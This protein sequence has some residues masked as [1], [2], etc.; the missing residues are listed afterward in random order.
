MLRSARS[1][2]ALFVVLLLIPAAAL[3]AR[4][5]EA[6]VAEIAAAV[7]PGT[8]V[9]G[10]ED[11]NR[12]R[13]VDGM[14]L[15]ADGSWA[16]FSYGT[17]READPELH[18]KSL[19]TDR[20]HVV[21]RATRPQLSDDGR[22]AAYRVHLGWKELEEA[23]GS[24]P[25]Q[26]QLMDLESAETW[27]WE[28]VDGFS[29]SRGGRA[30]AVKRKKS[31]E[32]AE[33]DGTDLIVRYL[34]NGTEELL[35]SVQHFAFNKTGT[36]LAY[37]VDAADN[38]GNG[39]HVIDLYSGV[40]RPLDNA[41]DDYSQ[42]AW[43]EDGNA[44]AVLRGS[45]PE[46][47]DERA[48]VLVALPDMSH[49]DGPQKVMFDASSRAEFPA[50]FVVSE[51]GRL[52]W[53]DDATKLFF[54]IKE[55]TP[56]PEKTEEPIADVN[57][58]H[59]ND[60][61]IQSVQKVQAERDKNFTYLS[62]LNLDTDVFVRL[63]T[64]R[65]RRFEMA[66]DGQYA[67]GYDYTDY[68]SD[69]E[70]RYADIYQ[71]NTATGEVAR[72]AEKQ[73]RTYGLSPDGSQ[74][75]VWRDDG[76]VGAI[77]GSVGLYD[78]EGAVGGVLLTDDAPVS[79][80]NE[81]WDYF[82]EKPAY[83]VAGWT[84]EGELL[85]NH[86]YDIWKHGT[87]GW[88]NLTGGYGAANEVRLRLVQTDPDADAFDLSEP[89]LLTAYGQWTKKSGYFRLP[90]GGGAPS[91]VLW[92]DKMV[93]RPMKARDADRYVFTLQ[94]F[95][96]F[97]DYWMTTIH[98]ESDWDRAVGHVLYVDDNGDDPVTGFSHNAMRITDA[99]PQH[100][101][102]KW[103]KRIL[104]D[105]ENSDGVKLQGT[106]AIPDDYVEGER[107]PMVV[108]FYEK[109]SQDLHRYPT[110]RYRHEPNFGDY[111]SNGYLV[112][113][114]D[115]HFRGGSSH[116]DMLECVEAAT[117]KVIEMGYAEPSAIGLSGHSYSGGGSSYIAARSDMFAAVASGAAP[118]NLTSE[119]NQLFLGTGGNN[120]SYDIYGQGRYGT[121]PY[122]DPEIYEYESPIT[123]VRDMDTPL[124]YLHGEE[125]MVVG[126][127]QATE[128]YN[129]LR[130]N[131][132]P[133]IFLSYPGEG[134]GLRQF[135]NQYDFQKRLGEFFGHHLRDE[136][137][138]RWMVEGR[139]Y[140]DKERELRRRER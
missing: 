108:R 131:S 56:E 50:D 86:R 9:L 138:A 23:E 13:T 44:L 134:H 53:N 136:T 65:L 46:G 30:L 43:S 88:E 78:N 24:S 12:W 115:V 129:A 34:W 74:F 10:L 51:R 47:M 72:I 120:H 66:D 52:N 57:V 110:V 39:L 81:E 40:R 31:D 62:V 69:W 80:V 85:L 97:P 130:F 84:T 7:E 127:V 22:W 76:M 100:V 17:R 104:F 90:A 95:H 124:L 5:Q 28:D 91:P 19:T 63:G 139:S 87:D 26:A 15:A 3:P 107:R 114:P 8:R 102:Y 112:M 41:Q 98:R 71:V 93:G 75:L 77:V 89:Q 113:Q 58:F 121:N 70:P 16:A 125:D 123:W 14:T 132:K 101:E 42:L 73:L 35:G 4:A 36:M 38:N 128:W 45:K 99:N 119:F 29:F 2:A 94:A 18:I 140:L 96:Q 1:I 126:Y 79:F 37:T 49:E 20:T 135:E 118:I 105:Y 109:Y 111:V 48:N 137:P 55:Q 83:G 6:E 60:E 103:G 54:G 11:Y 25:V 116:S 117:R 27:T 33:H 21:E 106:L 133:I 59:W 61:R 67:I 32:D 92:A 122:D 82:G 64:E 68:V